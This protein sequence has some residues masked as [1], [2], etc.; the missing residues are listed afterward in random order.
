VEKGPPRDR[1]SGPARLGRWLVA[2]QLAGVRDEP[3]L[4]HLAEPEQK[5]WTALWSKVKTAIEK[6]TQKRAKPASK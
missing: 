2:T 4:S 3:A 5:A 6:A 1:P